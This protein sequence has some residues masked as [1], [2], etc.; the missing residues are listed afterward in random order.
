MM[1]TQQE[2]LK[3]QIVTLIDRS[4]LAVRTQYIVDRVTLPEH[5]V[6][7]DLLSELVAEKRLSRSYT[8]LANGDP[9]CTYDLRS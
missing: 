4:G 7:N 8:L 1:K 6:L 5:I 3:Q 9:D 2:N